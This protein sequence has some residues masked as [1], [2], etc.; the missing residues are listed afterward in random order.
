MVACDRQNKRVFASMSGSSGKIAVFSAGTARNGQEPDFVLGQNA[1]SYPA[2]TNVGKTLSDKYYSLI[3]QMFQTPSPLLSASSFGNVD[4]MQF[5]P[6]QQYLFVGDGSNNRLLVFDLGAGSKNG[7][8]AKYV[9]G[10]PNFT[11]NNTN[12]VTNTIGR[13][14]VRSAIDDI[15]HRLFLTANYNGKVQL[16]VF[17]LTKLENNAKPIV[18]YPLS[19][20]NLLKDIHYD[21]STSTLYTVTDRTVSMLNVSPDLGANFYQYNS[22]N[23]STYTSS[24]DSYYNQDSRTLAFNQRV[25]YAGSAPA[26]SFISFFR[27]PDTKGWDKASTRR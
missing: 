4:F 3:Q 19:S 1:L 8:P 16:L 6:S 22:F 9:I 20:S 15:N 17:D 26:H 7:M 27:I 18:T 11:S 10:Q 2:Q 12:T 25:E 14:F 5:S 23:L 13:T 24:F 21:P